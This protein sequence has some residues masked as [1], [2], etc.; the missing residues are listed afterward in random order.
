MRTIIIIIICTI[1]ISY[2]IA[3]FLLK[4]IK[5]NYDESINRRSFLRNLLKK[6]SFWYKKEEITDEWTQTECKDIVINICNELEK[7]SWQDFLS[8]IVV[9]NFIENTIRRQSSW[10]WKFTKFLLW[11]PIKEAEKYIKK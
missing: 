11:D 3:I 1:I 4:V 9:A 2:I 7:K 5:P 8:K 6:W 10:M